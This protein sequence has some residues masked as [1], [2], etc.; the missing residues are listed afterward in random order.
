[1]IAALQAAL[2]V[3]LGVLLIVCVSGMVCGAMIDASERKDNT[4]PGCK[5]DDSVPVG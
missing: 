5:E 4:R 3:G 1:M 2:I